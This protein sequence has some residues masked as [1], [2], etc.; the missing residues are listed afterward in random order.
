MLYDF[1][2]LQDSNLK[3]YY[4]FY[5]NPDPFLLSLLK[6]NDIQTIRAWYFFLYN[7]KYF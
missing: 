6:V 1:T 2:F 7:K 3:N 5:D 4:K